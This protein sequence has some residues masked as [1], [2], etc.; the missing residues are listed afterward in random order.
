MVYNNASLRDIAGSKTFT[1]AVYIYT[2][3]MYIYQDKFPQRTPHTSRA[4]YDVDALVQNCSNSIANAL[5]V[6]QSW[7]KSST[8]LLQLFA[9]KW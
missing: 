9:E 7:T 3:Y 4:S 1:I 8:C 5:D 2:Y 6:S